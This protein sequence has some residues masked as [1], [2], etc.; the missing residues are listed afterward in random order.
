MRRALC[1][2]FP[3]QY[4]VAHPRSA[5]DAWE[6]AG[7]AQHDRVELVSRAISF[8]SCRH[9]TLVCKAMDDAGAA[10]RPVFR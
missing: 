4:Y 3:A 8:F 7:F 10:L 6:V 5:R 9:L 2:T 1:G